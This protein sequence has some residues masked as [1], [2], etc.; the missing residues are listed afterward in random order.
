K[1]AFVYVQLDKA[2]PIAKIRWV[3]G[4]AGQADAM[5][6]EVSTNKSTWTKV[7]SGGNAPPGSWRTLNV[8]VTARYVRFSFTNPNNDT[9][10]GG[11]AEVEVWPASPTP[12][13]TATPTK[14]PTVTRT[15]TPTPTATL[16]STPTATNTAT[17]TPSPTITASPTFQPTF[18][19]TSSSTATATKT[20]TPTVAPSFT[21]TITPSPTSTA[22]PT[23]TVTVTASPTSTATPTSSATSTITPSPTMTATV[24]PT[25]T[26]ANTATSTATPTSTST[27]APTATPGP[28]VTGGLVRNPSFEQGAINWYIEGEG[29]VSNVGAHGG[30]GVMRLEMGGGFSNQHFSLLPGNTYEL[31]V[32]GKLEGGVDLGFAGVTYQDVAGNRLEHLEPATLEFI[33]PYYVQK[34]LRFTIPEGVSYISVYAWKNNGPST[35]LVDDFYLIQSLQPEPSP[36]VTPTTSCQRLLAPSYFYP[37][38]GLW[39]PLVD[40]GSGVSFIVLNPNSGVDTKHEWRYDAPLAK[41][42]AAG[43]RIIGYIQTDYGTRPA[44]EVIAE[45]DRYREWYGVTSYFL[46]EADTEPESLALYK[47]MT[48]HVH[49]MGGIAV[50]NFGFRPHPGY[51]AVADILIVFEDAATVY[52]SYQLPAWIDDYPSHRFAQMIYGVTEE[53]IDWVMTKAR[54]SNA[55]YIWITDDHISSGSPYN[56]LPSYWEDLNALVDTGC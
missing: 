56:T 3:F 5:T 51:M 12:T 47:E 20:A 24:T 32:W 40:Q 4:I 38:T 35:F 52:A 30:A 34:T 48:D 27:P 19:P 39:D 11:L 54:E 53:N 21:R 17:A 25:A 22:T 33:Q 44:S 31:S 13:A 2:M 49:A 10:L 29:W 7:W 26:P 55:G 15:P 14:T 18:T 37:P 9:Y 16:T 6:V 23:V 28:P 41:A 43:I 36:S 1:T 45:M 8:D 50:L 42:R 46:D